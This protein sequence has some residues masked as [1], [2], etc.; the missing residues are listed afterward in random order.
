MGPLTA[1]FAIVSTVFHLI[2]L[3]VVHAQSTVTISTTSGILEGVEQNGGIYMVASVLWLD[4]DSC[5]CSHV[6]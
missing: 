5:T 3:R 4:A 6:I 2:G 1:V